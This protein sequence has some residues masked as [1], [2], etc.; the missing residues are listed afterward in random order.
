MQHIRSP[1]YG[2]YLLQQA[3]EIGP[4]ALAWAERAFATRD[5]PEQAFTSVQGM[6]S[7]AKDHGTSRIDAICIEAMEVG[8]YSGAPYAP[9]YPRRHEGRDKLN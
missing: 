9:V 8:N 4:N 1:D 7:L 2:D 3:R 5:F 6:I